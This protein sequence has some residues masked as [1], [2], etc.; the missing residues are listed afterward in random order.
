MA[1]QVF[2]RVKTA[3]TCSGLGNVIIGAAVAGFRDFTGVANGTQ[4]PY[5]IVGGDQWET[6]IG[7]FVAGE[8]TRD[9][10]SAS[11]SGGPVEFV[12]ESTKVVLVTANA[13]LF[14]QLDWTNV[15]A[16][17]AS[18]GE[19]G[20]RAYDADYL[21]VCVAQDTWKRVELLTWV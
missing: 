21:Y 10:V 1:A 19:P 15:P 2:D 14:D 6:G 4:V 18:V 11:S 12:A 3:A 16:T 20:Q 9:E 13:L 7:T 8:I 17:A 5:L